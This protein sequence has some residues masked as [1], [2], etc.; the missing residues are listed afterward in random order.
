[1]IREFKNS[2]EIKNNKKLPNVYINNLELRY[3]IL[4]KK[5]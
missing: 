2:L 4:I 1:M 3:S 5:L